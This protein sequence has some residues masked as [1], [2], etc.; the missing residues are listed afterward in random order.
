MSEY[1]FCPMKSVLR[2]TMN[3]PKSKINEVSLSRFEE[4]PFASV[5]EQE[6][7]DIRVDL[8]GEI[9]WGTECAWY[10]AVNECCF[11]KSKGK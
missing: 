10:D 1:K 11:I 9:C 8:L 5:Q 7:G 2:S 6:N 4:S 3:I